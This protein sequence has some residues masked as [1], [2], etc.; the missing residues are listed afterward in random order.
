VSENAFESDE[1]I[2]AE[3][4][5]AE[6]SDNKTAKK[7]E[8]LTTF[9]LLVNPAAIVLMPAVY[10][11]VAIPINLQLAW[12]SVGLDVLVT[13]LSGPVNA[14]AGE[15]GLRFLPSGKAL[16]G[17]YIVPRVGGA[18][19]LGLLVSAEIGYAWTPGVFVFR[20]IRNS[21]GY[22]LHLVVYLA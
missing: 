22:P 12:S 15:V 20:L 17:L 5:T 8:R 18:E 4:I 16:T 21:S 2:V 14:V 11:L 7:P 3:I 10:D 19:P 13:I 9:A 1:A 6:Q